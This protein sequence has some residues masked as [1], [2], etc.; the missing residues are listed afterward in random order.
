MNW[1]GRQLRLQRFFLYDFAWVIF[2]KKLRSV[3]PPNVYFLIIIN[4]NVQIGVATI[5]AASGFN[6]FLKLR[7]A[8]PPNV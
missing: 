5:Q 6:N 7:S 3:S 8:S 2:L 1:R 4:F